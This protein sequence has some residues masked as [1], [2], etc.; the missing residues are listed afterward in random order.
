MSVE[1][2]GTGI[3]RVIGVI[4]MI[5]LIGTFGLGAVA[6]GFV[7]L[8]LAIA[9]GMIVLFVAPFGFI[10]PS[11]FVILIAFLASLYNSL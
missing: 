10:F 3:G 8:S 9:V 1:T 6:Q 5:Y 11:I 4:I 7:Y 2:V